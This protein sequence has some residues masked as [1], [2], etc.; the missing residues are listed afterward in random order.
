MLARYTALAT[1]VALTACSPSFSPDTYSA[2]AV[3]QANKVEQGVVVGV[4]QVDVQVAGTTGAVTGGAAGAIAGSQLPGSS[5]TQA[6]GAVGG[7]LIGGLI[8]SGV[9][10]ATGD[11][12]AYEYIVRKPNNELVSVTQ[13]DKVPMA[14]GQRVLVIAGNQARIVPDYTTALP[15]PPKPAVK[16]IPP[17]K[18]PVDPAVP[19]PVPAPPKDGSPGSPTP[20]TPPLSFTAPAPDGPPAP[21]PELPTPLSL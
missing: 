1:L 16:D 12:R 8:G 11:T 4:R 14:L 18:P 3:Q 21:R 10:K 5:A 7:T 13:V 20:A 19:G 6:L 9:E 15:E 2:T 17:T